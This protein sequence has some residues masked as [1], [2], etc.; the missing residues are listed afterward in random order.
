VARGRE[1]RGGHHA[2]RHDE[3]RP[4]QPPARVGRRHDG[5]PGGRLGAHGSGGFL[6]GDG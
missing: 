5:E 1:G 6:Y 4:G 2:D 3:S